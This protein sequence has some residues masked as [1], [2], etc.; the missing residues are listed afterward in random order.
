MRTHGIA[1]ARYQSSFS[2]REVFLVFKSTFTLVEPISQVTAAAIISGG[3]VGS[4]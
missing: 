1:Q 3:V 2:N 4:P